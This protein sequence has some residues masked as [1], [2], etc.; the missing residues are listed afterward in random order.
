MTVTA[1]R[2]DH[3]VPRPSPLERFEAKLALSPTGCLVWTAGTTRGG[4]GKFKVDGQT[5]VAHRWYYQQV[6]GPIADDLQLDH[7]C[8]NPPCCDPDHLE[9]VTG[10]ENLLRGETF[11]A[12]NAAKT[13]CPH[14]HPLSGD[15]LLV[16][17]NR[18]SCRI[19]K[20]RQ[21]AEWRARNL[22]DARRRD[23]EQAKARRAG[24]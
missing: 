7:L 1:H 18:R 21:S 16:S 9:P 17:G 4:Y 11:Q 2:H 5:V 15:N 19:C 23:R 12:A 8:R 3:K 13:H 24:R 10:R 14:G 22:D 20:R 6:R